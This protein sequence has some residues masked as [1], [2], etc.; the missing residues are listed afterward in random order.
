MELDKV[1]CKVSHLNH[2]NSHYTY[3]LGEKRIE[4]SPAKKDLG[5]LG[6]LAMSQE[7]P[8]TGQKANC[9][10][11]SMAGNTVSRSGR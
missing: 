9:T 3:K 2:G 10:L 6:K 5:V 11:D 4:R 8:F 7:C 1:K